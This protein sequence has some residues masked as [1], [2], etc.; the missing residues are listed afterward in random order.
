MWVAIAGHT[1]MKVLAVVAVVI[2]TVDPRFPL[3]T[4]CS[5]IPVIWGKVLGSEAR[6]EAGLNIK[7]GL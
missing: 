6:E 3:R 7:H 2:A 1:K 5:S 4:R